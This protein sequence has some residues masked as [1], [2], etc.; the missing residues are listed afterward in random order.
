[1]IDEKK[2]IHG[3]HKEMDEGNSV[4]V[5]QNTNAGNLSQ[6]PGF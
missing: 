6:G 4:I 2:M 3:K 5:T 1:L